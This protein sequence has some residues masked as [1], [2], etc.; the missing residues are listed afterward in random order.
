MHKS[1]FKK[2]FT[3][4]ESNEDIIDYLFY[5]EVEDSEEQIVDCFLPNGCFEIIID[6]A[7]SVRYSTDEGVWAER[8]TTSIMGHHIQGIRLSVKGNKFCCVGA[9]LKHGKVFKL[10]PDKSS[11]IYG[12]PV[13]IDTYFPDSSKYLLDRIRHATD[14]IDKIK[15]LDDFIKFRIKPNIVQP[16]FLD[17][18]M[19]LIVQYKGD[20]SMS[21]LSKRVRCS[22]RHLR[23]S[24]LLH[25]GISPK[26]F[27]S[28][29]RLHSTVQHIV[30]T[31]KPIADVISDHGYF[32][33]AHFYKE[34]LRITNLPPSVYF[35]QPR[36]ISRFFFNQTLPSALVK[37]SII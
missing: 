11:R 22:T 33:R 28:V 18:S 27:S 1:L 2:F 37:Q 9:V 36:K 14:M 8:P 3:R 16:A 7:D 12:R 17:H 19:Q 32:D 30:K 31:G 5:M 25:F 23:R 10:L 21:D 15:A 13:C 6:L 20:I 29:I 24:F 35:N 34:F 26:A 4:H